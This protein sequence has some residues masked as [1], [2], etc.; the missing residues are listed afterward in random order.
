MII[1]LHNPIT[2]MW[3]FFQFSLSFPES[4]APRFGFFPCLPYKKT[5][6]LAEFCDEYYTIHL[7]TKT[8]IFKQKKKKKKKKPLKIP[9]QNG[10]QMT[11]CCFTSFRKKKKKIKQTNTKNKTKQKTKTKTNKNTK[12]NKTKQKQNKTKQ[13][14]TK[15]PEKVYFKSQILIHEYWTI[16]NH[17]CVPVL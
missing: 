4:G 8:S 15:K 5:P 14:K 3:W 1:P 10:G 17:F 13:N 9:F 2:F 6:F 11:D 7:Y 12:Q 16:L